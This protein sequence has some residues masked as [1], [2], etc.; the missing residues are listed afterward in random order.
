M[1]TTYLMNADEVSKELN[2]SRGHAYK[3]IR[4][5][6]DELEAKGFYIIACKIPRAFLEEKF[7][8]FAMQKA[9]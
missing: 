3:L 2:C 9:Q 6:N 8:G 1:S 5:M 4:S 7:Y